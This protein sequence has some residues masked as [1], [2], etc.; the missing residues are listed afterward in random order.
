MEDQLRRVIEAV[1][2]G[3]KDNLPFAVGPITDRQNLLEGS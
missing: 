3:T 1:S 2:T